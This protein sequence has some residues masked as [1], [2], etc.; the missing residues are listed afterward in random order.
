MELSSMLISIFL[1]IVI[2]IA[3]IITISKGYGFKHKVDP[4]VDPIPEDDEQ[5][6]ER[7]TS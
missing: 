5:E 4:R 7:K 1:T 2:L 3:S 6:I